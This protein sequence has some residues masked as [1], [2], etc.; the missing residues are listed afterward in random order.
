M[1]IKRLIITALI[2]FSTSAYAYQ[3]FSKVEIKTI[4]LT[5]NIYMLM[6]AGG[7]LGLSVGENGAF[8]I[9]DQYAPLT[10]KILAAVAKLTLDEQIPKET[11]G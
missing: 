3:D 7:N 10:D 6:G 9:D 4:P 1:T 8:L 2:F 11:S 5:D